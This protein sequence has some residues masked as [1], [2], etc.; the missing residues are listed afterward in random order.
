M[1]VSPPPP[2]FMGSIF[3]DRQETQ[4][5]KTHRGYVRFAAQKTYE[6]VAKCYKRRL[7]LPLPHD[8]HGKTSLSPLFSLH[9][10][11][12]SGGS[13]FCFNCQRRGSKR[14]LERWIFGWAVF[15]LYLYV[16]D[17]GSKRKGGFLL[18]Q[19][20]QERIRK[21]LACPPWLRD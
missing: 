12:P 13:D 9:L 1:L 10:A 19:N 3:C 2:L 16:D 21:P 14:V 4:T 7:F 8:F 20:E 5:R 6:S 17:E 18:A 15:H 11:I